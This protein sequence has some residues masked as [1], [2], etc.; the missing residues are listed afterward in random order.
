MKTLAIPLPTDWYEK[1]VEAINLYQ[2]HRQPEIVPKWRGDSDGIRLLIP[3]RKWEMIVMLH[4]E[5]GGLGY[6]LISAEDGDFIDGIPIP[7]VS[8][9]SDYDLIASAILAEVRREVQTRSDR[10]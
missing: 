10:Y 3:E 5:D 9:R 6:D 7:G 1:V 2:P 8:V 4:D